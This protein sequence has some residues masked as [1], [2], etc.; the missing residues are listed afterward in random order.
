MGLATGKGAAR[1]LVVLCSSQRKQVYGYHVQGQAELTGNVY[2]KC[3]N[4]QFRLSSENLHGTPELLKTAHWASLFSTVKCEALDEMNSTLPTMVKVSFGPKI[5]HFLWFKPF[6]PVCLWSA[7]TIHVMKSITWIK[8][9]LNI[10]WHNLTVLQMR[11]H[12]FFL[13]PFL[14]FI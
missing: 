12:F 3:G 8:L 9:S 2:T 13:A 6:V 1:P 5:Q 10:E 11:S 7:L 14:F 4:Y